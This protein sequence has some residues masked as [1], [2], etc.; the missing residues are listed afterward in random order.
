MSVN[1]LKD[2]ACMSLTYN[3]SRIEDPVLMPLDCKKFIKYVYFFVNLTTIH[4]S[5]TMESLIYEY[6]VLSKYLADNNVRTVAYNNETVFAVDDIVKLI[7]DKEDKKFTETFYIKY[8]HRVPGAIFS[9]I[10]S[11]Y[12]YL[13][14]K[15][16][17]KSQHI[18]NYISDY[19]NRAYSKIL[20]IEISNLLN[21]LNNN[22]YPQDSYSYTLVESI[23]YVLNRLNIPLACIKNSSMNRLINIIKKIYFKETRFDVIKIDML[24]LFEKDAAEYIH[25]NNGD[26]VLLYDKILDVDSYLLSID[27]DISIN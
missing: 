23:L 17:N 13:M 24:V 22:T 16:V 19:N 2:V 18:R 25:N 20:E 21:S 5:Y 6:K 14:I 26:P 10:S 9:N 1:M 11:I 15:H 27:L 8:A 3:Y 4:R 7:N 12:S